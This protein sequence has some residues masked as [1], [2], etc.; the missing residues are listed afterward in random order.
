MYKIQKWFIYINWSFFYYF[1]DIFYKG[2]L[3]RKISDKFELFRYRSKF[4]YNNGKY[5]YVGC[6]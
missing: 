1:I 5:Y 6:L 3:K 2:L 4:V